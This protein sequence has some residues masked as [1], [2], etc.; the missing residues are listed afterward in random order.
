MDINEAVQELSW[1]L[2]FPFIGWEATVEDFG[3]FKLLVYVRARP[4]DR[5]D[6]YECVGG[7]A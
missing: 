5:C 7:E 1:V 3:G 6:P 2:S 4:F